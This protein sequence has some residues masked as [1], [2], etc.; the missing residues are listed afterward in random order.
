MRASC[1][2]SEGLGGPAGGLRAV[3]VL[4]PVWGGGPGRRPTEWTATPW[5]G[6][7]QP[8]EKE[9]WSGEEPS[10]RALRLGFP[11]LGEPCSS[12]GPL[13]HTARACPQSCGAPGRCSGARPSLSQS[14]ACAHQR[15]RARLCPGQ[16]LPEPKTSGQEK[17][18]H[19]WKL[20]VVPVG[21]ASPRRPAYP[22]FQ[23]PRRGDAHQDSEHRRLLRP[24]RRGEVRD[25]GGAGAAL[26][27]PAGDAAARAQR[28]PCGAP[29]PAGLP[30]PHVGAVSGRRACEC[31]GETA[32]ARQGCWASRHRPRPAAWASPPGPRRP[33]QACACGSVLQP[34]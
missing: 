27:R 9:W 30:G 1:S 21:A 14:A 28:G 2:P 34:A 5:T 6:K 3:A 7:G 11:V 10:E 13:K 26:H 22:P 19:F 15:D 33:M 16:F 31:P 20:K 17:P 23:A 8:D 29:A 25:A 32:S 4:P 24:V 18:R 12:P